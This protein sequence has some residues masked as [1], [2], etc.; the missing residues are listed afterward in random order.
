MR[1]KEKNNRQKYQSILYHLKL[2]SELKVFKKGELG[3]LLSFFER[4]S[5]LTAQDTIKI[6]HE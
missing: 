6:K 2:G 1:K 5:C 3:S 4:H